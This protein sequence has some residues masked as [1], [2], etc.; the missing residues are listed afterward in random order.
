MKKN[1]LVTTGLVDTW[2]FNEN[3]YLLGKW[4]EYYEETMNQIPK[5]T[6]IIRNTDHW[7]DNEKRIK[8]YEYIK[9]TLKYL[10]EVI[11]EKLCIIHNVNED[12]EY[13]RVVIY[14]WLSQY[15]PAIFNKWESVRIFFEKNK[16][17]KFYTNFISLNDANYIPKSHLDYIKIS[18][19]DEWN[20][21]VF[22]RLFHFLN[23]QNL[24]L[25]EKIID[26]NN[27]KKAEF[28]LSSSSALVANSA[29]LS[30]Q[31]I[32]AIDKIISKHAFN[33]NKI[34]LD[35]FYFPKKEFLKIC[36]RCKLI[37]CKYVNFFNFS[38]KKED[39]LSKENKRIKLKNLLLKVDIKDKF[40]KFL[41]SNLHKDIPESYLE[42]FDSIK[43]KI[44]P[45]A[46]QK[47]IIFS[48]HS[49][50]DN[51]NFK[52][53]I[54]ETKKFGS[55]LIYVIHGGGLTFKLDI[56]FNFF[57][58]VSNKI[59]RWAKSWSVNWDDA[60][61][62][63]NI[64]ADLSPTLP[65]IKLKDSK[66]GTDC[67]ILSIEPRKYAHH[68]MQA[69][70]L[71]Q[72]ISF[73]NELM[74]FIDKLNPEIQSKVKFRVKENLGYNYAKRFSE[75]FDKKK[76]DKFSINNPLSK[77][78]LNSKLIITTYPLTA[79]C[80]AMHANIPTILIIK[81]NHWQFTKTSLDTFEDL[82]KNH[83]AFDSFDEAKN[84]IN[85]HW[86]GLRAWWNTENVQHARKIYLSNFYNVKTDWHK[87]WSDYIYFSKQL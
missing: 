25:V 66:T 46:K 44:L 6:S 86:K 39:S 85:K 52:I 54:A 61:Q 12:K 17:N 59:I 14:G 31:V 69:P 56:R 20:H 84:H 80:E 5:E 67:T 65:T 58:K 74:Q 87:E 64:Y 33:Y 48:M 76:I 15:T 19:D 13:W 4:C 49:I 16:I 32:Q 62:N 68:F 41:L 53:Y 18:I 47:K 21:L 77:R 24:S 82:K 79:F 29:N 38:V 42:N 30:I 57:E 75:I 45:F 11:S 28:S 7:N 50:C 83:I 51:D 22:L 43:E 60:E 73:F 70:T 35:S 23:I 72:D 27:I 9:K 1:F 78:L 2:E 71:E 63:Q 3:N 55:K 36:L 34:I 8:D 40:I 37:P 81:K 10:L 26:K